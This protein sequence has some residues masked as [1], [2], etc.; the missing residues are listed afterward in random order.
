MLPGTAGPNGRQDLHHL[1]NS[2]GSHGLNHNGLLSS[3]H[4][5][6]IV[7]KA[8]EEDAK[9]GQKQVRSHNESWPLL[10]SGLV[11]LCLLS[12]LPGLPE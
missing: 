2:I 1:F 6:R 10:G 9:K 8:M 7:H 12:L 5:S 4:V 11:I 3:L